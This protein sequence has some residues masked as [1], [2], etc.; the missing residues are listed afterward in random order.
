MRKD[1]YNELGRKLTVSWTEDAMKKVE[2]T[3]LQWSRSI[4]AQQGIS[5]RFPLWIDQK[6]H[7]EIMCF[8]FL[9]EQSIILPARRK[10]EGGTRFR[11]FC[12][13]FASLVLDFEE[14][15]TLD[16]TQDSVRWEARWDS[17]CFC[18]R[19]TSW[20][21]LLGRSFKGI[22]VSGNTTLL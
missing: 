1:T 17:T 14:T 18:H 21:L 2:C 3:A 9:S 5:S 19:D 7:Q 8:I 13:P 12:R 20:Y 4:P 22:F 10:G 16:E 6:G 15:G 11:S